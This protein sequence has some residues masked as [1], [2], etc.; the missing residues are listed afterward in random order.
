MT[1]V[2]LKSDPRSGF[3]LVYIKLVCLF[4]HCDSIHLGLVETEPNLVWIFRGF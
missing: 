1:L 3:M 2:G 4:V